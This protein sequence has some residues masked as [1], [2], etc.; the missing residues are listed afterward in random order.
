MVRGDVFAKL[1]IVGVQ[2]VDGVGGRDVAAPVVACMNQE[3]RAAAN[4]DI[5]D[6]EEQ[7]AGRL[8]MTVDPEQLAGIHCGAWLID[9][10]ANEDLCVPK[11]LS[12]LM[13]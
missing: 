13:T 9:V 4:A 11:T 10:K 1:W 8:A 6:G 2:H 7:R 5:A 3:R 12:E